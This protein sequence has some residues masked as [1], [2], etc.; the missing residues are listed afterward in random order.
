[1]WLDWVA[2]T[3]SLVGCLLNARKK[4][5]CWIVWST[6]NLIWM[7]LAFH[8]KQDAQLVLWFVYSLFNLYGYQ[9]WKSQS[10]PKN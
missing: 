8:R 5:S 4:I 3:F 10:H 6:G 9:Q 7:W 1:M 2:T